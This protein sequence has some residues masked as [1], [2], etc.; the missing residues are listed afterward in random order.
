MDDTGRV[1]LRSLCPVKICLVNQDDS[2]DG[3]GGYDN[4]GGGGGYDWDGDGQAD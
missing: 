3:G 1:V 2:S 4:G